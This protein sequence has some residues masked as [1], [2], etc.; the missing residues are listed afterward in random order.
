[1]S[2]R[3]FPVASDLIFVH[4]PSM[5]GALIRYFERHRGEPET[6]ANHVG[7]ICVD[8]DGTSL[9]VEALLTVKAT[10]FRDWAEPAYEIWRHKG[11]TPDERYQVNLKALGYF[12]KSYGAWKLGGHLFDGIC[13][14]I[15]GHDVYFARRLM[16]LDEYPI[17]SWV[18]AWAY[19]SIGYQ[20]GISP[21]AAS[22]D[23]MH[24]FV[25]SSPDW[26]LVSKVVPA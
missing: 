7:G 6:Y 16:C 20:F 22:P 2:N 24:D 9:V 13:G 19:D 15:A 18:W 17:C 1:M 23:I 12:G 8:N 4:S 11:L 26:S 3:Y 14:K 5:L 21:R 10:P 25:T